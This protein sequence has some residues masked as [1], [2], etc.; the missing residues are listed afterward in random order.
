[1]AVVKKIGV[2]SIAKLQAIIMALVR[3]AVGIFYVHL[4]ILWSIFIVY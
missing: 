4:L 1:M 2:L 3:L